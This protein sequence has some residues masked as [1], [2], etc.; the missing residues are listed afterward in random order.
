MAQLVPVAWAALPVMQA[1]EATAVTVVSAAVAPTPQTEECLRRA[2]RVASAGLVERVETPVL[3]EPTAT[4]GK[5][6]PV[7]RVV[8]AAPLQPPALWEVPEV[9][10]APAV[11]G[12]LLA[13]AARVA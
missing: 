10:E 3:V 7:A 5:A 11:R 2:I 8:R 1:W 12:A 9:P 6:A 4:V 13:W